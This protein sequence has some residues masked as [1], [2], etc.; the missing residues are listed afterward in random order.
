ME[1][2]KVEI[3]KNERIYT[4]FLNYSLYQ[5][6]PA[7]L[8]KLIPHNQYEL[9]SL[10]KYGVEKD[11]EKFIQ[12][13]LDTRK[14]F[15]DDQ[16]V[17]ESSKLSSSYY[18]PQITPLLRNYIETEKLKR[19]Q[20]LDTYIEKEQAKIATHKKIGRNAIPQAELDKYFNNESAIDPWGRTNMNKLYEESNQPQCSCTIS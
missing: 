5:A 19:Q 9:T 2:E 20:E 3:T 7:E 6:E 11:D 17:Q 14:P 12:W 18:R 16:C 13:L 8:K 1:T 4:S 10:F 15:F